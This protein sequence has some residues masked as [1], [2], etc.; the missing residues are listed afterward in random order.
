MKT[1]IEQETKMLE[2]LL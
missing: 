1:G 2:F